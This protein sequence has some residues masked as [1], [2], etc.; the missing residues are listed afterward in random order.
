MLGSGAE[1][2]GAG[3]HRFAVFTACATFGLIIAGALVTSKD[4]GLAVPD[5][6]LSYGSL[7]P[8]W[9]GNIRFEHGHRMVATLVGMLTIV[10]AAWLWKRE[11]RRWVKRLGAA[12]LATVVAQGVLGGITVLFFLP[13]L[14]SVSHACLAQI[15]FC[16]TV[17]LALVTGERWKEP[18]APVPDRG[19]PPLGQL[20]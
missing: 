13:T 16:L 1:R 11:P 20:A 15:F 8:P 18:T 17:T 7:M 4:A 19:A 3:L 14:I 5:W 10:L 9:V 2:G 6:P 12:A